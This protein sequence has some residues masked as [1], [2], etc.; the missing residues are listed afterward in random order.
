MKLKKIFTLMLSSV[1]AAAIFTGC[2]GETQSNSNS[3]KIGM[4]QQLNASEQEFN[5]F[6]KSIAETFALNTNPH[7]VTYFNNLNTMQMA[8]ESGQIDEISTYLPVANYLENKNSNI[9]ILQGHTMEFID[10]FCF[11]LRADDIELKNSLDA[12]ISEMQNDGTLKK[13]TD[14]Y[15][16]PSENI[17]AVEFENFDGAQTLKVAVTGDLP[18]LDMVQ[19]DGNAAGFNTAVLSEIGKRLQKNIEIIQV[20]SA[21]RAAALTSG[22]ADIVFWAIVP[23][24]EI[25]PANA[26]KP[27]GIELTTP[28]YRGRIVHIGLKK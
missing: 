24:S 18:P 13:L 20:D 1:F 12:A 7:E 10:A 6:M 11:A 3:I 2:G 16:K 9:E 15:I 17:P 28:Y 21:S 19:A 27:D 14:E 8:L 26:D 23:V 25:I 5:G 22:Q 4:L